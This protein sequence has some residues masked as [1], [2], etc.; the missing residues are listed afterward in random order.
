MVKKRDE[1]E[2]WQTPYK[3]TNKRSINTNI[4][5]HHIPFGF[6][7]IQFSFALSLYV[8]DCVCLS[9]FWWKRFFTLF[10]YCDFAFISCSVSFGLF[11]ANWVE[12]C[13]FF[14]L[15]ALQFLQYFLRIKIIFSR[16]TFLFHTMAQFE[17]GQKCHNLYVIR[18]LW[19]LLLRSLDLIKFFR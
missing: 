2:E 14:V 16:L 1:K 5:S 10:S 19:L 6:N 13:Q 7:P 18:T 8:C 9:P 3:Q 11:V 4:T 12:F 17:Q 15:G